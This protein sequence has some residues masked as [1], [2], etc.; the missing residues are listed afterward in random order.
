MAARGRRAVSVTLRRGPGLPLG[1]VGDS[2]EL[3]L[4]STTIGF[5]DAFPTS[6]DVGV[7]SHPDSRIRRR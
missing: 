7:P 3:T 5:L 4:S 6:V 2:R 1:D